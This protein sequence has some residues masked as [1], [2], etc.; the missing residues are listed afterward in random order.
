MSYQPPS[1][2]PPPYSPYP[3]QHPIPNPY[4][5]P[6]TITYVTTPVY[7]PAYPTQVTP[8]PQPQPPPNATYVTNIYQQ[9]TSDPV[10]VVEKVKEKVKDRVVA[11]TA[12]ASSRIARGI[13]SNLPGYNWASTTTNVPLSIKLKALVAGKEGWDGS[14]LY[15]IRARHAGELIPGK[16]SIKHRAAYVPHMGKEVPVHNFEIFC[17]RTN[18]VHWVTSSH[19]QVPPGAIAAGNTE[20]GDTLYIARVKHLNSITPGKV[21]PNHNCCYISFGGKEISYATYE[22]LCTF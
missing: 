21:H 9:S 4:V 5:Q 18:D 17:A 12:S 8:V 20:N 16:L 6:G 10:K 2:P 3:V 22:V 11:S 13:L 7:M 1:G 19:G 15:I 14:Q